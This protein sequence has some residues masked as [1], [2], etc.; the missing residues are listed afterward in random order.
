MK[1]FVVLPA[2]ATVT[3]RLMFHK[4]YSMRRSGAKR[5][6]PGT[7]DQLQMLLKVIEYAHNGTPTVMPVVSLVQV[8]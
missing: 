2:V 4:R 1:H 5:A 6:L 7:I 3:I 8:H